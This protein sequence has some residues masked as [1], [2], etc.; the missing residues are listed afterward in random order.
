MATAISRLSTQHTGNQH[1]GLKARHIAQQLLTQQPWVQRQM[2]AFNDRM[3]S[4]QGKPGLIETVT[5]LYLDI[6]H[7][8]M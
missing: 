5:M 2:H 3:N 1:D 4:V 6:N 8:D 7:P